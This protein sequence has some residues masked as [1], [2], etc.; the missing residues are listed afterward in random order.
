MSGV[1]REKLGAEARGLLREN[2]RGGV[3]V[4][5]PRLYPHQWNWDSAFAAM[6]WATFDPPRALTE[7]ERLLAAAWDNGMVPHTVFDPALEGYEPGPAWW[8]TAQVTGAG[9]PTSSLTQPP[10][11]ATALRCVLTRGDHEPA[12]VERAAA[13]IEPLERRY[14]RGP[15]WVNTN[16]LLIRGLRRFRQDALADEL[17]EATLELVSRSGFREYFDPFTGKGLGGERFGW[18]AALVLDLLA[19][20]DAML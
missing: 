17:T 2:D 15:C 20:P 12:L 14:W 10:V 4:P 6:G 1:D 13:L 18:S 9:R 3:T 8:R 7:L 19:P 11:A 5:S 16:W